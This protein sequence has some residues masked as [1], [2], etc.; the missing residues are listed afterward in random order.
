MIAGPNCATSL[1]SISLFVSPAEIRA[2]MKARIRFATGEVDWSIVVLQTGHITSPES[3]PR[4]GCCSL[5]SAGAAS[6]SAAR[7]TAKS[8]VRCRPSTSSR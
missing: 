8:L 6:T 5:A 7:A 3:S 1:R 2:A 4:V